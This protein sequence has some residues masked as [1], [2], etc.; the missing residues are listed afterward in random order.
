MGLALAW[1]V[2]AAAVV[3]PA[4]AAAT[5]PA[6]SPPGASSERSVS[7]AACT[8]PA[9]RAL[10]GWCER[11]AIGYVAGVQVRSK[12]LFETLDAHG[13]QVD[14]S[15]FSCP[16]CRRA[17]EMEGFCDEHKVGFV[18]KLAY[19]S[20][21]TYELARGTVLDPAGI[22]CAVCRRN[23]QGHGW[24][25]KH[26]VGMAGPF[27]IRDR[28]AFQRV[29][30][31]IGILEIANEAAIRCEH[32]AMAIVTNTFCP[33]HRIVYKDGKALKMSPPQPPPSR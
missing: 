33:V 30:K 24:C 4:R 29:E 16:S 3:V 17:I 6:A 10:N 8:C 19:F 7:E 2:L 11:H 15:T 1:I 20:R 9:A 13:H 23:A 27:A 5:A 28:D 21:L 26:R 14:L 22:S 25:G 18:S 12:L 31:A 32:C